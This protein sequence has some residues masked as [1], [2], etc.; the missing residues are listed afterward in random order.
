MSRK[1]VGA[2]MAKVAGPDHTW[3]DR[4]KDFGLCSEG[5]GRFLDS[6]EQSRD[7]ILSFLKDH[8]DCYGKNQH[9]RVARVEAGATEEAM[10][11]LKQE[12]I[13]AS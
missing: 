11:I 3:P 2:D 8:S 6:T 1:V 13:V 4:L 7:M 9:G 12:T 10:G 5:D